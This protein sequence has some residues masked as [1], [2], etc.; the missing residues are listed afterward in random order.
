MSAGVRFQNVILPLFLVVIGYLYHKLI[1]EKNFWCCSTWL[2]TCSYI[3]LVGTYVQGLDTKSHATIYNPVCITVHD[4]ASSPQ[5]K[6]LHLDHRISLN[7]ELFMGANVRLHISLK[8]PYFW[9]ELITATSVSACLSFD[10]FLKC[11]FKSL[12]YS[13]V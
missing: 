2:D 10:Q 6:K 3:L 5:R 4:G 7:L 13:N 8:S 9:G 1:K 12:Y 11:V